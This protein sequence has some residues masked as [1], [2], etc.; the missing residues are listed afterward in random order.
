MGENRMNK[1]DSNGARGRFRKDGTGYVRAQS[2]LSM[3]FLEIYSPINTILA[4]CDL[5]SSSTR[6]PR[7]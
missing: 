4:P 1:R 3:R 5:D 7:R 6:V 2:P